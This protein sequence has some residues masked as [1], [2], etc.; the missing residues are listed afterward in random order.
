MIGFI[1]MAATCTRESLLIKKAKAGRLGTR[2]KP[3][4]M[5]SIFFPKWGWFGIHWWCRRALLEMCFRNDFNTEKESQLLKKWK[6]QG[7]RPGRLMNTIKALLVA[8]EERGVPP[9]SPERARLLEIQSAAVNILKSL[10]DWTN[11]TL[12]YILPMW[13]QNSYCVWQ[14]SICIFQVLANNTGISTSK[15]LQLA[16]RLSVISKARQVECSPM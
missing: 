15:S 8:L 2:D 3:E 16:V 4:V 7:V 6:Q 10:M 5:L 12:S 9:D 14:C 13:A 11:I 1:A